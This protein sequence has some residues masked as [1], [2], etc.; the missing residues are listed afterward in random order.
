MDAA[1]FLGKLQPLLDRQRLGEAVQLCEQM[2]AV[3]AQIAAQGLM[4]YQRG[5]S[6]ADALMAASMLA[7]A[8]L[9]EYLNFLSAIVTLAPL[10]GLLG[11][12]VGMIGSFSVLNIKAGQPMAITGGVGEALI[13]TATGLCVAVIAFVCHV[14]LSHRLD[15]LISD[16]ELVGASLQNAL[17]VPK[18]YRRESHEIA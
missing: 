9:R 2:P 4:A 14:Y 3:I 11:T 1:V 13:A 15:K 6:M 12:V 16:M 10:L 18:Q 8:R 5:G 17:P 7:A